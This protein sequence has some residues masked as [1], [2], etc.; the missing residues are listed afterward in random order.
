MSSYKSN[1]QARAEY[2]AN[3]QLNRERNKRSYERRKAKSSNGTVIILLL[4]LVLAF[5]LVNQ[6]R[7]GAYG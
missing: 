7:A 3:E 6:R 2:L 1:R 5:Y 4:L